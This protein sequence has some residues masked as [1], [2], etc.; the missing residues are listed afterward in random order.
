MCQAKQSE[1]HPF[2]YER[3]ERGLHLSTFAAKMK[4][5]PQMAADMKQKGIID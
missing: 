1:P 2:V 3:W 4:Y 5:Y